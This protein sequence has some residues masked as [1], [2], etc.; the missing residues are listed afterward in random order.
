[1][2]G[3]IR[4]VDESIASLIAT[5]QSVPGLKNARGCG[6]FPHER[7]IEKPEAARLTGDAPGVS[8]K[9][10]RRQGF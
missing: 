2:G 1:M 5:H 8:G 7:A 6:A 4:A 10:R 9:P 3:R